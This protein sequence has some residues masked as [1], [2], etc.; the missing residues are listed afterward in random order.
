MK[1]IS[2]VAEK[3][4][5]KL[6]DGLMQGNSHKKIDNSE[7]IF[8]PV[9]VELIG[10]N[11]MGLEYS[12]AHYYRQNGDSMADPEMIFWKGQDGHFYPVY[13]KQDGLG[14]E[15]ISAGINPEN[16]QSFMVNQKLQAQHAAFANT[17]MKNIKYQQGL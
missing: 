11:Y 14:I 8:M 1:S 13:Y 7:S 6:I 4:M 12:V 2:Q 3:V 16:E 17:W 15:Q 5:Y 10:E 9:V